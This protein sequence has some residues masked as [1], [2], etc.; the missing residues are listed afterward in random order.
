MHKYILKLTQYSEAGALTSN[1]TFKP[2]DT[3]QALADAKRLY[4]KMRYTAE[5]GSVGFAMY[6]CEPKQGAYVDIDDFDAFCTI[7][8]VLR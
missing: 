8:K 1:V 5:D 4:E 2:F 6:K 7:N 3:P